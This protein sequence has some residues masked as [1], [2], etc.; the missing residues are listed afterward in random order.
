MF[1]LQEYYSMSKFKI[2]LIKFRFENARNFGI[3]IHFAILERFRGSRIMFGTNVWIEIL[4]I[5]FAIR[6]FGTQK[7]PRFSFETQK[8]IRVPTSA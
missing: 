5:G 6:R 7:Q 2:L 3:K 4:K 8:K 1:A